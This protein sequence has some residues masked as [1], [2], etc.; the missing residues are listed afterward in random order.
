MVWM[1]ISSPYDMI[2]GKISKRMEDD[3]AGSLASS[4]IRA[5]F[6]M[7]V[8]LLSKVSWKM[9]H[10]YDGRYRRRVVLL[11]PDLEGDVNRVELD[12]L[13]QDFYLKVELVEGLGHG[14]Q[15]ADSVVDETP[16]LATIVQ[17][18]AV[19][20]LVVAEVGGGAKPAQSQ[21]ISLQ[22]KAQG[23]LMG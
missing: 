5:E 9:Q 15:L 13:I 4:R 7:L 10:Q 14:P 12:L 20:G 19:V 21:I 3:T 17:L 6:L 23:G 8:G 18:Q 1:I 11:Q 22:I 16:P 2:K